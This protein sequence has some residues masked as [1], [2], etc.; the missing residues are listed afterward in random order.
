MNPGCHLQCRRN[1]DFLNNHKVNYNFLYNYKMPP[2]FHIINLRKKLSFNSVNMVRKISLHIYIHTNYFR[3]VAINAFLLHS[4]RKQAWRIRIVCMRSFKLVQTRTFTLSC[5]SDCNTSWRACV[6][7]SSSLF[8]NSNEP[9]PCNKTS[10]LKQ[11]EA[12][13][14]KYT[15]YYAQ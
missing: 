3:T 15:I 14:N 6:R 10:V 8:S 13:C 9:I 1:S 5:P 4:P 12:S 11:L 7:K 2:I